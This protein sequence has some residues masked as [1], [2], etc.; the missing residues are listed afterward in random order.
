MLAR[1]RIL[2]IDDEA[3]MC[4]LLSDNLKQR[5]YVTATA[6][7]GRKGLEEIE[8]FGP[9]L[10]LLDITMPLMDGW[11]MLTN[12]RA[13]EGSKKIPVV[14]ITANSDTESVFK[15]EQHRVSDYFIKPI[16]IS[17]LLAFIKRYENLKS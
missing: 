17:E 2:I 12:L 7:D 16:N 8:R 11:S 14:M 5:G 4:E 1:K 10:I 9:D 15:S 3:G 6:M 13:K